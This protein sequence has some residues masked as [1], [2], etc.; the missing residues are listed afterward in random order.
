MY[1]TDRML[2]GRTALAGERESRIC[3]I[4]LGNQLPRRW[5]SD[6][7]NTG[8]RR[9]PMKRLRNRSPARQRRSRRRH[10][11][12]SVGGGEGGETGHLVPPTRQEVRA[13][14]FHLSSAPTPD[15]GRADRK[16]GA[17]DASALDVLCRSDSIGHR[18]PCSRHRAV[19]DRATPAFSS[20]E[21]V[22]K[23][24]S[25]LQTAIRSL[26]RVVGNTL[27]ARPKG[28]R[29][30]LRWFTPSRPAGELKT[31][32]IGRGQGGSTQ[33]IRC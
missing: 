6:C 5:P 13:N 31:A 4:A 19:R 30:R 29:G 21:L 27:N 12:D 24:G 8:A 1:P 7:G 22:R 20:G 32:K 9:A 25:F 17:C 11:V 28:M 3:R 2:G 33:P 26:A 10:R 23:R 14:D 16:A 15:G 18:T